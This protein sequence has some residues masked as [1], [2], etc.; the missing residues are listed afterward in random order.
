VIP[1]YLRLEGD[2]PIGTPFLARALALTREA[3]PI[4]VTEPAN[5]P[6]LEAVLRAA[7]LQVA[8]LEEALEVPHK[9][10]VVPFPVADEAESKAFAEDLLNRLKPDAII[11]I[12][13][14][15]RNR[16]GHYRNG[17]TIKVTDVVAKFDFMIVEARKR[18]ILTIGFGDGGN[19]I[20][21]GNILPTI[22][23]YVP[24]GKLVGAVTQTD[25]LVVASSAGWGAY[26]V[27][28]CIAALS[29]K[30]HALHDEEAER[31]VLD[32]SVNAGIVDPLTGT[33]EGYLDGVPAPVI[34]AI[35]R[36]LHYLLDVRLR[37]WGVDLYRAWGARK[38][39]CEV[40]F[41]R[42]AAQINEIR[43]S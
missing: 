40:L 35:L 32:A 38:E 33:A 4:V 17:M 13:K 14:P 39:E 34:Y 29:G 16:D 22:E 21:M 18:K 3:H 27:E 8:P 20:G 36:I 26:G 31:R 28:A 1:P 30:P 11:T 12:E 5:V 42:H 23:E 43:R 15:G 2:G 25:I 19:E 41:A 24:N 37:P 6:A 7:G 9:A 10:A